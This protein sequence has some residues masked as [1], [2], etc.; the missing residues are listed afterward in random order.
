MPEAGARV[1]ALEAGEIHL[2]ETIDGP[3][4]KRLANDKRFTIYKALPFALQ[5]IKFNHAQAPGNDVNFRRAVQAALDMEEIMA[6]SYADIYQMDRELALSRSR[7]PHRGGR[8]TSSTRPISSSARSCS[9][10]PPTRAR[11]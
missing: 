3:T 7:L 1:A 4:A 10:S 2:N 6:I 8:A 11:S 9:R 5:V